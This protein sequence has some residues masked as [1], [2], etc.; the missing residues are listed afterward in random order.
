MLAIFIVVINPAAAAAA[1]TRT[2]SKIMSTQE[3]HMENSQLGRLRRRHLSQRQNHRDLSDV[4]PD[5]E[6]DTNVAANGSR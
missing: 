6:D 3:G 2:K 5:S 1:A 4:E